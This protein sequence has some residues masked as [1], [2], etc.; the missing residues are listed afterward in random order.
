M[1]QFPIFA[2]NKFLFTPLFPEEVYRA[3]RVRLVS[4]MGK[5]R[6]NGV[7]NFN[8]SKLPKA[9]HGTNSGR[10]GPQR[11]RDETP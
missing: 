3:R 7:L 9:R 1:F 11:F 10:H 4:K 6:R 8:M 2:S 5:P